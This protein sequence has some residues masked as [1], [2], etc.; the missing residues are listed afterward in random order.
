MS[1]FKGKPSPEARSASW[2]QAWQ[3]IFFNFFY[4]YYLTR[5]T[6][7]LI[8]GGKE[9][10]TRFHLNGSNMLGPVLLLSPYP[11]ERFGTSIF[12][13][14]AAHAKLM[15][16]LQRVCTAAADLIP[17][18][19]DHDNDADTLSFVPGCSTGT[20]NTWL[21]ELLPIIGASRDDNVCFTALQQAH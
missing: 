12:K 19:G 8:S 18:W 1:A 13:Q 16:P 9:G 11:C 2:P 5:E 20:S 7:D 17:L 15:S 10:V 3:S 21:P 14:A 4:Y 6:A